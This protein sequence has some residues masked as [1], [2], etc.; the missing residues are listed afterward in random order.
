[1]PLDAKTLAQQRARAAGRTNL[2]TGFALVGFVG[3]V[4]YYC[5]R[6]AVKQGEINEDELEAFKRERAANKLEASK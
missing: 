4:F 6:L 5:T 1:M 2:A 3:G